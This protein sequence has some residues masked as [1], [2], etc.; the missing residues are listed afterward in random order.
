[1]K[2][3]KDYITNL[4]ATAERKEQERG[5]TTRK[6]NK[7]HTGD[8]SAFQIA[9]E[10]ND[11]VASM[12]KEAK[13]VINT[14]IKRLMI[15]KPSIKAQF[16]TDDELI[17]FKREFAYQCYK[18]EINSKEKLDF[19]MKY[20]E[21]SDKEWIDISQ[22]IKW[23]KEGYNQHLHQEELSN[24]TKRITEERRLLA[25]EP[26]EVRKARGK[27]EIA[28]MKAMLKNK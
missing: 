15:L 28:K 24:N 8:L 26:W 17:E 10:V 18:H 21:D 13:L 19:G 20:V 22:F 11:V 23:C 16:K 25:S 4:A 27:S 7:T 6:Q 9:N 1:M 3:L 2:D 12:P 5:I 14:Y